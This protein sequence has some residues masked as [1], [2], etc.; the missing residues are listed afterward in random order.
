M[1]GQGMTNVIIATVVILGLAGNFML[2]DGL[3]PIGVL[4]YLLF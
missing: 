1:M 4:I 3:N 2:P